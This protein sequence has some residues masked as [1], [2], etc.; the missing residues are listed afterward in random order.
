[1]VW[2]MGMPMLPAL[3]TVILCDTWRVTAEPMIS[4]PQIRR[5]F[6]M[7]SA[8]DQ[9]GG[10]RHPRLP[11]PSCPLP[12]ASSPSRR[13]A[14][15]SFLTTQFRTLPRS[16]HGHEENHLQAH[17][18]RLI[19]HKRGLG[20]SQAL[21]RRRSRRLCPLP[22]SLAL[23]LLFRFRKLRPP[24]T[25]P[26]LREANV[27]ASVSAG[28]VEL[29]GVIGFGSR[30]FGPS[31]QAYSTAAS[32]SQ[33]N[34]SEFTEMAWE[35]IVGT[36]DAARVCKQQVVETEHLMK[37]LL[38]RKD[39]LARRILTKAVGNTSGPI[40]N[41]HLAS[42]SDNAQKYKKEMGDDFVS[43]EHLLLA[44]HSDKR[45]RQQLFQNLQ[46]NEKDFREAIQAVRGNQRVTD[47]NPKGKYEALEK[48]GND[49]TE[50]ARQGKLDPVISHDN[51]IQCC[52]Q[53]LCRRTK[54]NPVIIVEPGV[55]KTAI[56]EG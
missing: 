34:P 44:L 51:E 28:A 49:L 10:D 8:I 4:P 52:I 14:P 38:E 48:Y 23:R 55:G 19:C 33:K 41:S 15:L 45:F 54:N 53:I 18:D 24:L 1:M 6:T 39:G 25:G 40:M 3:T 7:G 17:R 22:L 56:A 31:S 36:V 30:G 35:G 43:V 27:L 5:D 26:P 12:Q 47:Q 20:A 37:A 2:A 32:A 11:S 9:E 29:R 21:L 50:M 16:F 46:L 42:F 13:H